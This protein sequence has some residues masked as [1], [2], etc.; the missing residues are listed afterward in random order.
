MADLPDRTITII[1]ELQRRLVQ[2]INQ[3]GTTELSVFEIFGETEATASSVLEQLT[4]IR[5]RATSSYSHLSNLL[6]R[7]S[8]FQPIAP[9]A[10]T[11]E[12]LTQTIEQ[13][14]ATAEAGEATV[15]EAKSDWNLL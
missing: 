10:T 7:I 15:R 9:A 14:K 13:A 3:A 6:L 1:L 5:E 8:E 4:N 2:L 11:I 12:L